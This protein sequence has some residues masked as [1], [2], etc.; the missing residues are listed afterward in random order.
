[1]SQKL[2]FASKSDICHLTFVYRY[3]LLDAF[4]KLRGCGNYHNSLW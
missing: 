3:P 1:M 2:A 4:F